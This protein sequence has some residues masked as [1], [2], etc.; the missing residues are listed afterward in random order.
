M[1]LPFHMPQISD[2]ERLK[3]LILKQASEIEQQRVL[4]EQLKKIDKDKNESY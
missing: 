2:E 1:I 4:I 3:V